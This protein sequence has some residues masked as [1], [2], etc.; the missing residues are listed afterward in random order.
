MCARRAPVCVCW[1]R[2]HAA[3]RRRPRPTKRA[4]RSHGPRASACCSGLRR[5]AGRAAGGRPRRRPHLTP[6]RGPGPP[7]AA[8]NSPQR[9]P[10][11]EVT[12]PHCTMPHLLSRQHCTRVR[13]MQNQPVLRPRQKAPA[14]AASASASRRERLLFEALSRLACT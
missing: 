5:R 11:Y 7:A 8:S 3:F 4:S 14:L 6:G 13:P 9:Q 12:E 2:A 1:A 10:W